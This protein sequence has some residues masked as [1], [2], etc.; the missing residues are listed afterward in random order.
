MK[1]MVLLV[2][3][4][5]L[6]MPARADETVIMPAV[7]AVDLASVVGSMRASMLVNSHGDVFYGGHLPIV[8]VVGKNSGAEYLNL[9][10]GVVYSSDKKQADFMASMGVR[11]DSLVSKFGTRWPYVKTAKLPPLEVGPFVSYGFN[12]W[13]WGAMI[14]LRLGGK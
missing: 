12:K 5:A 7:G 4:A 13:M 6:A 14:S 9:N 8:T 1:K 3:L 10:A 2:V 11:V